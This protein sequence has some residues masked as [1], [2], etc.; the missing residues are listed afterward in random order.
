MVALS[1]RSPSAPQLKPLLKLT[2]VLVSPSLATVAVPTSTPP[3]NSL[4]LSPALAPA[5]VTPTLVTLVRSALVSTLS[6]VTL[7]IMMDVGALNTSAGTVAV[8]FSK[9]P[10]VALRACVLPA[11]SVTPVKVM[12]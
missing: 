8:R 4:M 7:L 12:A 6:V 10:V 9:T 1:E 3:M 2:V 5:K 11:S